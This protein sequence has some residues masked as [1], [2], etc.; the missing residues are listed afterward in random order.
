MVGDP[1]HGPVTRLLAL[2]TGGSLEIPWLTNPILARVSVL[3]AWLWLSVGFGMI[4]LLAALQALDR[5]LY[6]A[7]EVDGAG[8]WSRFWHVTL[9][10]VRPVLVFLVLIGLIG[11]FQLFELPFVL[12]QG[13]GPNSAGL[14]IVMYL[15]NTGFVTGDLGYASAVGWTLALGMLLVSLAQMRLTGSP[16]SSRIRVISS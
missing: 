11:G 15:Y 16:A 5:N 9:P 12:L 6:E 7:A 1:R 14:T 10:G 13:A 2:L 4:Y 3:L 8:S